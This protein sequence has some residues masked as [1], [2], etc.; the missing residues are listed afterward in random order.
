[1]KKRSTVSILGGLG[2]IGGQMALDYLKMGWRVKICDDES[3]GSWRRMPFQPH[4][5]TYLRADL[6]SDGVADEAIGSSEVV[7]HLAS[8]P[9]GIGHSSTHGV[10]MFHYNLDLNRAVL[11]A[12]R[13]RRPAITAVMSSSCVYEG[14]GVGTLSDRPPLAGLPEKVNY[15]YG[16]AKRVL[17]TQAWFAMQE[18]SRPVVIVRPFN[19]YGPTVTWQGK[20]SQAIPMLVDKVMRSDCQVECWGSGNQIRNYLHTEDFC[21]YVRLLV[22]KKFAGIPVNV[23]SARNIKVRKLLEIIL[24]A[25]EKDLAIVCN[26]RMPEGRL[27]KKADLTRLRKILG[28]EARENIRLEDGIRQMIGWWKKEVA[29]R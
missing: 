26:R 17:E 20:A 8:K 1:M 22:E 10:E 28:K 6:R 4:D 19:M 2:M 12:V 23:A 15:G 25:A 27:G 18:M 21:R 29:S 11:G 7:Y 16:W 14:D 3:K 13:K 5:V 9:Y 24:R